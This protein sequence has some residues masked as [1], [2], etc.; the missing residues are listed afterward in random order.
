MSAGRFAGR[1]A[2]VTG[3]ARGQGLAHGRRLAD[4]GAVVFLADVLD[5]DGEAA[6]AALRRD[7]H[8]VTYL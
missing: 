4:E 2:L 7:G 8:D 3:G 5:D 6:A 1:T